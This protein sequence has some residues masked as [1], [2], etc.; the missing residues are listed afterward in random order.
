MGLIDR[1]Q[2]MKPEIEFMVVA[3]GA[4]VREPFEITVRNA[5]EDARGHFAAELS[6][7]QYLKRF[8]DHI[9]EDEIDGLV[10]LRDRTLDAIRDSQLRLDAI[11][12]VVR[13]SAWV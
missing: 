5:L 4:L 3:S 13:S 11:R 8:N 7:L 12:I 6:R 1:I 2:K 9:R 10:L